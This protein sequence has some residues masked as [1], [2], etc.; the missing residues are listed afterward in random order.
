MYCDARFCMYLMALWSRRR[1]SHHDQDQLSAA[2]MLHG[3]GFCKGLSLLSQGSGPASVGEAADKP[4]T[5]P[6][7]EQTTE[8]VADQ[9]PD[10]KHPASK[11]GIKRHRSSKSQAGC[12]HKPS[13]GATAAMDMGEP[14]FQECSEQGCDTGGLQ[15]DLPSV[16]GKTEVADV[17]P[18]AASQDAGSNVISCRI[19]SDEREQQLNVIVDHLLRLTGE[20]CPGRTSASY[21]I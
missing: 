17:R 16:D 5:V 12:S 14:G 18:E 6:S 2:Y 8:P 19:I 7:L 4:P 13:E 9:S 3:D 20:T 21:R 11:R 1:C 15:R 10:S